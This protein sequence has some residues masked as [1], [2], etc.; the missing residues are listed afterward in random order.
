MRRVLPESDCK[1]IGMKEKE[2]RVDYRE[3]Q[4]ILYVEKKDGSYGPMRTGSYITKN[5]I[6]DYWYKRHNLEKEY[7]AKVIKG[8][9]S[10]IAYY[11]TIEELTPS[12]L[13]SRVKIPARRVKK[14][15]VPATFGTATV[16]ELKRYCGVFGVPLS[17]MLLAVVAAKKGVSVTEKQTGN[18]YFSLIN[19]EAAKK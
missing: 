18:P 8:E 1:E 10:P 12:E 13:A 4:L 19:I 2:A 9:I 3:H 5:Y 15:L 17:S 7:L 16:D 11:M 14:H 6:D